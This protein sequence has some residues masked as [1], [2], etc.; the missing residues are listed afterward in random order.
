MV[1]VWDIHWC[2]SSIIALLQKKYHLKN[3]PCDP[4]PVHC[5]L[6]W[7]ALCQEHREMKNNL[8]E[9][10]AMQMTVVNPPPAQQMNFGESQESASD[11]QSTRNDA[12]NNLE[13]QPV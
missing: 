6:H 12:H 11:D 2:F 1:D 10:A 8:S 13:I 4:C 3:S 9:N 5:C 7:C